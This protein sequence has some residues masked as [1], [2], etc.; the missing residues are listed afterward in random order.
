MKC[1]IHQSFKVEENSISSLALL[2]NKADILFLNRLIQVSSFELSIKFSSVSFFSSDE[3]LNFGV[4]TCSLGVRYKFYCSNIVRTLMVEPT[5]EQQD[6]YNYLLTLLDHVI[7]KMKPGM[8][9][10]NM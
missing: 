5:Q 10:K 2:G 9:L 6:L 3:K 8:V 7:G 1:A 4:I